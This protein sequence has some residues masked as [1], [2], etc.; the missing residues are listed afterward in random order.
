M[1]LVGVRAAADQLKLSPSTVSRYLT[2]FPE[3]NRGESDARP[4]VNVEELREH[5]KLNVNPAK[6]GNHAGLLFDP[7]RPPPAS[8]TR[9]T[10]DPA[11]RSARTRREETQAI[12]AELD[13]H[14]RL[15]TLVALR[16]VEDALFEAGRTITDSLRL[17]NQDIAATLA[18]M[19]DAREIAAYLDQ[20]DRKLLQRLAD[21][22]RG[23]LLPA[24]DAAA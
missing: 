15:K 4:L 24:A 16:D 3:L 10:T 6:A 23:K 22:L 13:L 17:R 11:A 14:E 21:E 1:H 12:N 2:Q 19:T 8:V 7:E 9:L 20:E 18:G 5:R